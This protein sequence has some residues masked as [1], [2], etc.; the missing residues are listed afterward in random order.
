MLDRMIHK[1]QVIIVHGN[2]A[3]SGACGRRRQSLSSKCFKVDVVT[4]LQSFERARRRREG[5]RARSR[6]Y[7]RAITRAGGQPR[8]AGHRGM[9]GWTRCEDPDSARARRRFR[10][11]PQRARVRLTLDEGYDSIKITKFYTRGARRRLRWRPF[12]P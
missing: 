4:L 5:A 12:V 11:R 2:C 10:W 9:K 7:R 1:P 3:S 8:A 6:A